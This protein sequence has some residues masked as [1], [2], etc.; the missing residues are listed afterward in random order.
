MQEVLGDLV[1]E[2]TEVIALVDDLDTAGWASVTPS[3]PWTIAD[4]IG[5]LAYFDEQAARS[6]TD[7]TSFAETVNRGVGALTSDIAALHRLRDL[8]GPATL[9]WWQSARAEMLA[10]FATLDPEERVPW[11]GPA[12]RARSAAVARLMETWAHGT[13][14]AETLG[15]VLPVTNRLFHVADL[16]VRTYGW[17]FANRGLEPPPERVRVALRG[18]SGRTRIWNDECSASVTGPVE[19]FCLVVAQRRNVRDTHLVLEGGLARHWM[20]IAQVFAGPPG[21]GR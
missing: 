4:Q 6:A 12:M 11:Y 16:G 13:D 20:E 15:A 17:A 3:A 1:D 9:A 8:D 2:T 21:P 19:E 14:I 10:A 5:H 18:P 7:P